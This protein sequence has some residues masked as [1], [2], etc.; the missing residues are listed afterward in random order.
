MLVKIAT[1]EKMPYHKLLSGK[2]FLG[3]LLENRSFAEVRAKKA[4][5]DAQGRLQCC[6]WRKF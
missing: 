1:V 5:P 4:A 3:N 6:K 2:V